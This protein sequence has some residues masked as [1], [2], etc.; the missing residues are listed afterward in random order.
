VYDR[1]KQEETR[2]SGKNEGDRGGDGKEERARDEGW[3][4]GGN[5]GG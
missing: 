1:K 4:I 5:G 2:E 3:G